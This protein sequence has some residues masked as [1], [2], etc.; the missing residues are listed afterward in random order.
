MN[1]D[2]RSAL[3]DVLSSSTRWKH[4][5]T[6]LY[7]FYPMQGAT[8]D[9]RLML[10]GRALY[11]WSTQPFT[12]LE[13][14]SEERRQAIIDNTFEASSGE[15]GCPVLRF[16]QGCVDERLKNGKGYNI[17]SSN[18]W[19]IGQQVIRQFLTPDEQERWP[20]YLYW[21]NL[22][23]L[24]LQTVGN[25]P[26]SLR[27]V[28]RQASVKMMEAEIEALQPKR[29]LFLTGQWWAYDFLE[30]NPNFTRQ[31]GAT[32]PNNRVHQTGFWKMKSLREA[33]VVV[34]DHPE[35]KKRSEIFA[36]V[37]EAFHRLGVG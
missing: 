11:G 6:G 5:T 22:Y 7:C 29:I 30:N 34:A 17:R 19:S 33:V 27:E 14:Q 26:G 28:I 1:L 24:S 21:T 2:I 10:V 9:G 36:D 12:A 8:A 23:K 37:M 25:P 4:A 31:E 13:M 20:S 15:K 16:Y 35:R 32:F 3:N 18:F